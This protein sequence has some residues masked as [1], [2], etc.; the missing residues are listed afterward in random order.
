MIGGTS[1]NAGTSDGKYVENPEAGNFELGI[2]FPISFS[3]LY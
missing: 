2:E 3:L 1:P